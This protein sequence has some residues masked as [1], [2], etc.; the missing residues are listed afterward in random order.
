ML[1]SSRTCGL[2]GRDPLRERDPYA[3]L[4]QLSKNLLSAPGGEPAFCGLPVPKTRLETKNPASSAGPSRHTAGSRDARLFL[5]GIRNRPHFESTAD[6]EANPPHRRAITKY[7]RFRAS[8][9][10]TLSF[11]LCL[12]VQIPHS[13]GNVLGVLG[14]LPASQQF[15]CG[16]VSTFPRRQK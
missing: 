14:V 16:I 6:P 12:T 7:S 3:S 8:V 5:S 13:R 4:I 11:V 10:S 15:H 9:K 2:R 1:C